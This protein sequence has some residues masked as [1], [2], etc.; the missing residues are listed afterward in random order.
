MSHPVR[1]DTFPYL[2]G[3]RVRRTRESGGG[4]SVAAAPASVT[5]EAH[6]YGLRPGGF[7][8]IND[9]LL[10]TLGAVPAALV[11]RRWRARRTAAGV[12]SP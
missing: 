11:T 10:D 9:V 7:T 8:L 12:I 3:V 1:E 5:V 4:A 6:R 2:I